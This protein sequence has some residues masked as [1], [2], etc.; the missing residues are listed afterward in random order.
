MTGTFRAN[1]SYFGKVS[2]PWTCCDPQFNIQNEHGALRY[3]VSADCCQCGLFCRN[4]PCG[5]CSEAVF[6]IYDSKTQDKSEENKVGSIKKLFSGCVQEMVSDADNFE[7]V[8]PIDA[9][10]QE[11]LLLIGVVLMIDYRFYESNESDNRRHRHNQY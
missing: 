10:P 2:E 6:A 1:N 9:T 3:V 5:K 7:I 8:F 4:Y 11:K